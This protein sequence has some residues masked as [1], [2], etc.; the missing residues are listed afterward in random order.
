ME[1]ELPPLVCKGQRFKELML[2]VFHTI[3]DGVSE[4]FG[5]LIH[6]S[7]A[8]SRPFEAGEPSNATWDLRSCPSILT[9]GLTYPSTL[10]APRLFRFMLDPTACH[11]TLTRLRVHIANIW[12]RLILD[13]DY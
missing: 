13:G 7:Q 6:S 10:D 8:G 2:R 5:A 3:A 1:F 11:A 4:A 12:V 9:A